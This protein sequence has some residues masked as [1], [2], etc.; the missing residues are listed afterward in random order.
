MAEFKVGLV[1]LGEIAPYFVHACNINPKTEVVAVCRRKPLEG[2]DLERY[3]DFKYYSDWKDLVHDPKVNT[4]IIA[5][6]PSTHAPI[7][8]EAIKLGKKVISEKPFS[9]VLEDAHKCI[10]LAKEKKTHLNFAYHAAM[11]PLSVVARK[12]VHAL[13]E[14]GDK[15][16]SINIDF[17]EFVM[18][19]HNGQS[20]IFDAPISGGG[21][22]I[23][24]GVNAISTVQ[25]VVGKVAPTH[26]ELVNGPDFKVETS[27]KVKFAGVSHP[28][29]KGELV[30]DWLWKGD[31]SRAFDIKFS[32]GTIIH[33][34]FAKGSMTTTNP[35]GTSH[36]EQV[37]NKNVDDHHLTPMSLEYIN[38]VNYAVDQFLTQEYVDEL[39][40]GP[41]EFVMK[42]YELHKTKQ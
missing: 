29:L 21:V 38:V 40:E 2:A 23:D 26:V 14:K 19:Y 10:A 16:V 11:N 17:R 25:Y 28:E 15:V 13:L 4:I 31:E 1:G 18:N 36:T 9:T 30:Q 12:R 34:C 22:L 5:T 33:F 27:C 35:D 37:I 20:W 3:K 41:F 8:I 7:T 6:P 42:A 32:S 24:S 39:G